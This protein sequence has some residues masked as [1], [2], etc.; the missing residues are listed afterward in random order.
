MYFKFLFGN[1]TETDFPL[2]DDEIEDSFI[3]KR[4]LQISKVDIYEKDDRLHGLTFYDGF[5]NQ[6][7]HFGRINKEPYTIELAEN[8][9]ICGIKG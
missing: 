7:G 8:E 4:W 2:Y 6:I 5:G 9:I 1:G 3:N